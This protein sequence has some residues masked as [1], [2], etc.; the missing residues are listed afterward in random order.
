MLQILILTFASVYIELTL[1]KHCP[2]LIHYV[3]KFKLV[4]LVFSLA[5]S[6]VLGHIFGAAGFTCFAAG[7]LST[8]FANQYWATRRVVTEVKAKVVATPVY[9][10][11]I[12][13][14]KTV[15]TGIGNFFKKLFSRTPQPLPT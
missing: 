4:A 1:L 12:T 13:A 15:V 2:V 8:F 7:L 11:V 14:I 6:A 3:S 5:L 9:V 10:K